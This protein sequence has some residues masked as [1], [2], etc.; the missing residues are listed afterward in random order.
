MRDPIDTIPQASRR[1]PWNNQHA[2][3]ASA[4]SAAWS[5]PKQT[6]CLQRR[7]RFD[8][9]CLRAFDVFDLAFG[10]GYP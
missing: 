1:E 4:R 6:S 9:A 8:R 5:W 7:G 10:Q 2:P 3:G